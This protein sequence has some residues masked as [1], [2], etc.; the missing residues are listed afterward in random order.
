MVISDSLRTLC[1]K[2]LKMQN[3]KHPLKIAKAI[4]V[5]RKSDVDGMVICSEKL[6]LTQRRGLL[7]RSWCK[8]DL[9]RS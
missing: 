9:W 2:V 8:L 5:Q 4:K 1:E 3:E 7:Q 6:K